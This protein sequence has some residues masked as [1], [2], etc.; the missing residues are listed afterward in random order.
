[1]TVETDR[2]PLC[3][4][5]ATHPCRSRLTGKRLSVKHSSGLWLSS[6]NMP[7]R[8]SVYERLQRE[9]RERGKP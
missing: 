8:E 1:M 3:G 4:E 7:E 5:L 2:C 9:Q 6:G